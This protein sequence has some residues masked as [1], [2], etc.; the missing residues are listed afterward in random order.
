MHVHSL[1]NGCY[2]PIWGN[3]FVMDRCFFIPVGWNWHEMY[4]W[5]LPNEIRPYLGQIFTSMPNGI[6]EV[7]NC[8]LGG[9]SP[10][11]PSH[12]GKFESTIAYFFPILIDCYNNAAQPI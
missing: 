7:Q 4:L 12:C 6:V 3:E 11:L 8:S 5:M 1:K 9:H 2:T 10:N